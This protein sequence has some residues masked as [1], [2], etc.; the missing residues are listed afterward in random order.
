M[1]PPYHSF[2]GELREGNKQGWL[3]W[4]HASLQ[5]QKSEFKSCPGP[6]NMNKCLK[7][8]PYCWLCSFFVCFSNPICPPWRPRAWFHVCPSKT[9]SFFALKR[10]TCRRGNKTHF[11]YP[12]S[13]RSCRGRQV[14]WCKPIDR[15]TYFHPNNINLY[16]KIFCLVG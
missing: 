8:K 7:C 9:L 12:Y 5:S 16:K 1:I 14:P 4:K 15:E 13:P 11:P 10:V 2:L 6:I 3:S